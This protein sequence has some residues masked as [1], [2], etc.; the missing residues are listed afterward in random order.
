MKRLAH[1]VLPVILLSSLSL[2]LSPGS[3]AAADADPDIVGGSPV[4]R[5]RWPDVVSVR[6]RGG[7][8]TGTLIA[9]D[10][11][12]TAGH[13]ID[14]E[15]IEVIIDTIDYGRA[16]GERIRVAWARAY[17]DW[18]RRYDIGVLMLDHPATTAKPRR[19]TSACT[20]RAL[21]AR[22]QPVQV[23]GFGLTSLDFPDANTRLHQATV[24]VTD[25]TCT[26]DPSCNPGIA[27][28]G[29]FI[30]GGHG[31]DSC[32][33]DSGG[34]V[35]VDVGEGDGHVL[36]GVVSRGLALPAAACGNGGVYVRVDKVISWVQSV[37]GRKLE[38]TSC[39]GRADG[40]ADELASGG[41]ASG[42]GVGLATAFVLLVAAGL[43]LGRRSRAPV[44]A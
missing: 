25:P 34:P 20:A 29:E 17:P 16:G 33:G 38:R 37:T 4:P 13:C 24:P 11:V 30:A 6:M 10:V 3:S 18:E 36:L 22:D 9:P 2:A 19:V 43:L 21:L 15:P 41:C 32:F 40:D 26:L 42:P 35:Y 14:A 12:L 44:A 28:H 5:G 31:V 27:P 7:M 1:V 23:V 39:A 8:C